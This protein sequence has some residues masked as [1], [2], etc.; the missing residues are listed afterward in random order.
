[1]YCKRCD[2]LKVT[3]PFTSKQW[4]TGV[5]IFCITL[6]FISLVGF[7]IFTIAFLIV[8]IYVLS[9]LFGF[10]T[11]MVWCFSIMWWRENKVIRFKCEDESK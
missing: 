11:F 4:D 9:L 1:M 8:E 5:R 7:P 6:W 3:L 10:F 2:T